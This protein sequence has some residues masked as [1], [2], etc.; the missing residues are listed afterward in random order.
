MKK[1]LV[2]SDS[3][4]NE[5]NILRACSRFSEVDCV[6]HLGD[7]IKDTQFIAKNK[8]V[9]AVKGNCDFY[10]K[11][12][13][14]RVITIG[15]KKILMLHGHKQRVKTGLLALGL[16]AREKDADIALFGHTHIPTEQMY[17]GVLLYNPGSL[18]GHS[19]PTIGIITI[20]GDR[21]KIKTYSI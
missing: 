1:I 19:Q 20:D 4:G 8:K 11:G 13:T 2:M 3:H 9:Y 12:K 16:Y 18:A 6:I 14:E 7:F 5:R 21:V 10:S 15:G 17:E